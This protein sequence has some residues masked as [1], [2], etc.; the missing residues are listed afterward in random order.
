[1]ANIIDPELYPDNNAHT[2]ARPSRW[3][4]NPTTGDDEQV[5]IPG[6][7]DLRVYVSTLST[8]PT[9]THESV[10]HAD[11]VELMTEIG[12]TAVYEA[13]L[14]GSALRERVALADGT[15]LFVHWQSLAAG[16][17][18]FAEVIW[19]TARPAAA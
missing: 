2:S 15:P 3:Q 8:T 14:L 19:R 6:L 10:V 17:H 13:T 11:L 9:H 12:A 4:C 1:M 7:T 16:H 18:E 5:A